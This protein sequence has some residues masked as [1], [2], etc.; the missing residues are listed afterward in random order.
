ML[1]G[2][3]FIK[4]SRTNRFDLPKQKTSRRPLTVWFAACAVLAVS[5]FNLVTY[6]VGIIVL[7]NEFEES[8]TVVLLVAL[9]LS[10]LFLVALPLWV[11]VASLRGSAT[12]AGWAIIFFVAQFLVAF[13]S[14]DP[15]QYVL[16]A[17][18]LAAAIL[19]WVPASRAYARGRTAER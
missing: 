16:S 12:S 9:S 8:T 7:L 1:N 14:L 19:L 10:A 2:Q 15:K 4:L 18:A 5:A 11:G 6:I 17:I 3:G 13:Q